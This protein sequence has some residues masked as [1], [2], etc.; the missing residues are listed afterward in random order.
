MGHDPFELL[1][2]DHQSIR[3]ALKSMEAL[4]DNSSVA[5]RTA[6]LLYLKRL[7]NKHATAEE[8]AVYPM[9]HDQAGAKE[10]AMHLYSEH[11]EMKMH[12]YHL[13]AALK[14]GSGWTE[15]VRQL[16]DL[17]NKHVDEEESTE[18]P[19]LRNMMDE[20]KQRAMAG[21]IH[22]EEAMVL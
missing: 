8:D 2:Q 22:R 20:Q 10:A 17:I 11:A 18:F 7:L 9:L 15:H 12:L 16:R 1:K 3:E 4:N 6:R 14:S 19:R 21:Q 13:E 5:R